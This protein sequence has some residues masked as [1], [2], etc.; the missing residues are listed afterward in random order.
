[1]PAQL[2]NEHC[3]CVSS[4][5]EQLLGTLRGGLGE[6]AG[7]VEFA[8]ALFAQFPVFVDGRVVRQI[9]GVVSAVHELVT[10]PGFVQEA[11]ANA[12]ETAAWDQGTQGILH[13]FD[14][15]LSD[16]G[17]QLIEI[18]TNAGGALL[19]VALAG[20]QRACCDAVQPFV[21]SPGAAA[22][23]DAVMDGFANEFSRA[24]RGSRELHSV[25]IVDEAPEAQFLYPEFLLFQELFRKR[26]IHALIVDPRGLQHRAGALWAGSSRIDLVYN[27]LTDFYLEG[28]SVSELRSAVR[29]GDVVLTPG[30]RHHALL[31]SKRHLA[32]LS[33]AGE[34][35][36]FGLSE[37]SI[38][39]LLPHVPRAEVVC[40]ERRDDL[41]ARRK[42]LFFKPLAGYGGKAAYRGDKLTRSKFEDIVR[43]AYIAQA[44]VAPS[45]RTIRLDG[46]LVKLKLDV[47]AYVVDQRVVLLAARMYQGQTTN[48]RTPGGGFA[49]VLSM[50][51]FS[52][53]V[54]GVPELS[55]PEQLGP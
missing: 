42:S 51:E 29:A 19:N 49:T 24:R 11:L 34:L 16:G 41:F 18:N 53:P 37:A 3:Q 6:Q 48:F 38:A 12:P 40:A 35:L 22:V 23:H 44:T 52:V 10:Q 31:A 54:L 17:P 9:Q 36:K 45:E 14:F 28:A 7:Q 27:R 50:P 30:P 13:G 15:H 39:A 8:D 32:T 43:G 33:N 5:R 55:A 1:M 2:L 47:R 20:A 25:A 26:G 21:L 4:D 46:G